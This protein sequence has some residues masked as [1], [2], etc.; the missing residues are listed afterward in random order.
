MNEMHAQGS[1]QR[2]YQGIVDCVRDIK[3]NE[4]VKALWKGNFIGVM[5][6]FPNESLNCLGKNYVRGCLPASW[7]SNVGA[8]VCGGW[9]ASA[10]LYPIDTARIMLSTST[11]TSSETSREI[12]KRVGREGVRFL[13]QGYTSSML[14]IG[15]FRGTYFGV[16]DSFK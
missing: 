16:F 10:V 9:L 11:K 15:L 3:F 1:I 2:R 4:G 7:V 13:Y 12:L 8:G 14:N 6:F 5:R